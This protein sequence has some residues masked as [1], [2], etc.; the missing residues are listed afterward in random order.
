MNSQKSATDSFC[1]GGRH[2]SGTK[3]ITGEITVEKKQ[4]K[5]LNY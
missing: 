3:V 5:I 1:V 4:A 2:R